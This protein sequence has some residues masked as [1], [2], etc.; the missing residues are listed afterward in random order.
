VVVEAVV[1]TANNKIVWYNTDNNFIASIGRIDVSTGAG[2]SMS[3]PTSHTG[4][5]FIDYIDTPVTTGDTGDYVVVSGAFGQSGFPV[6]VGVDL[7]TMTTA[8]VFVN[9]TALLRLSTRDV[10]GRDD[11]V[12]SDRGA[13]GGLLPGMEPFNAHTG[14]ALTWSGDTSF[15]PSRFTQFQ[16][17]ITG[18][19][20]LVSDGLGSFARG[21]GLMTV[22]GMSGYLVFGR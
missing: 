18:V 12:L 15:R 17:L 7:N 4:T 10:T 9:T 2:T 20:Q 3:M 5:S 19:Q 16:P 6:V 21:G 13:S 8:W 22:P 14:A 11:C 1:F